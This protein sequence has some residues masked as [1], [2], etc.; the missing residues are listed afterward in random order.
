MKTPLIERVYGVI[1][2]AKEKGVS[3]AELARALTSGR[4]DR[5][6]TGEID[7]IRQLVAR[8]RVV[9]LFQ[10]TGGT[11]RMIATPY[12]EAFDVLEYRAMIAALAHAWRVKPSELKGR[13]AHAIITGKDYEADNPS[14][15]SGD[16]N[17]LP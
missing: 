14:N 5:L 2:G 12:G 13:I 6:N 7:A 15:Q 16:T 11:S 17:P 1:E 4:R 3:R 9:I 8:D 10:I